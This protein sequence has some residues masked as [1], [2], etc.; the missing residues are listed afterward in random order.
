MAIPTLYDIAE[1]AADI[2]IRDL[3]E[4]NYIAGRGCMVVPM[5][6]VWH[7]TLGGRPPREVPSPRLVVLHWGSVQKE[8]RYLAERAASGWRQSGGVTQDT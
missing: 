6:A 5:G 3:L 8:L 7:K 1:V 2:A 4:A